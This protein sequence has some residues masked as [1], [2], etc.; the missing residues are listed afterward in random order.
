MTSKIVIRNFEVRKGNTGITENEDGIVLD[1]VGASG[2]TF[3]FKT[4]SFSG[5]P[6]T[7]TTPASITVEG[8]RVTIPLSL[9]DNAAIAAMGTPISYEIE[10]RKASGAQRSFMAGNITGLPGLTDD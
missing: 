8:D 10:R 5:G 3:H 9:A 4:A 7:K 2:Y 6:I 1:I